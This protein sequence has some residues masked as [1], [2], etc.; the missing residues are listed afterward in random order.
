MSYVAEL[1]SPFAINN[2]SNGVG[3]LDPV[4]KAPAVK[5]G[6]MGR[7]DSVSLSPA[8]TVLSAAST[9][10]A[11]KRRG[12]IYAMLQAMVEI[13]LIMRKSDRESLINALMQQVRLIELQAQD[14][15]DSAK[16][17][18]VGSLIQSSVAIIGS[19]IQLYGAA[20]MPKDMGE[21]DKVAR[22]QGF[23]GAAAVLNGLGSVAEAIGKFAAADCDAD[24][25]AKEAAQKMVEGVLSHGEDTLRYLLDM[26]RATLDTVKERVGAANQLSSELSR[27]VKA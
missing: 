24:R 4:A 16:A 21:A 15:R 17:Q 22:N 8:N 25:V 19:C 2:S 3:A 20:S 12:D 11:D 13:L 10:D 23:A 26:I 6:A 27:N 1:P 18:L 14:M 9:P 5:P 7:V